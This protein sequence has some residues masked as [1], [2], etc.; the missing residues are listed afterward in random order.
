MSMNDLIR[1]AAGYGPRDRVGEGR[2]SLGRDQRDRVGRIGVGMSGAPRRQ[3][4]SDSM[5]ISDE[6]RRAALVVRGRVS[7]EDLSP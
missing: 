2:T 6:I 3:A 1:S 5:Q 7:I 4:R